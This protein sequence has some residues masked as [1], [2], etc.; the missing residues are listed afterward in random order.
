MKFNH[1]IRAAKWDEGEGKWHVTIHDYG[2]N[3]TIE[4]TCDILVS[5][6]GLLNAWKLPDDVEGLDTF[7]GKLVHT[8]RWPDEYG[9]SQWKHERVAVIGS[10][11]TS[12]QVVP[13]LQPHVK[14]MDVFVRT[15]VWFAEIADHSGDNFDCWL[16]P[17]VLHE[18]PD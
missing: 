1:A 17:I 9:A 5:A 11:A 3:E 4:E 12:I 13:T 8:A 2:R 10:G 16:Y 14:S 7:K 15:P 18:P 6:N